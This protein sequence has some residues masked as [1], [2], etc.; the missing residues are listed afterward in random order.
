MSQ[1]SPTLVTI[2]VAVGTQLDTTGMS[3]GFMRQVEPSIKVILSPLSKILSSFDSTVLLLSFSAVILDESCD[4]CFLKTSD[5][6]PKFLPIIFIDYII[7]YLCDEFNKKEAG[8]VYFAKK[9]LVFKHTFTSRSITGTSINT[10]TTAASE[11]PEDKPKSIVE[12][13]IATSK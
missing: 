11:A 2:T 3:S 8:N 12:V 5:N 1:S 10:P 7:A 13:A 6:N 9:C 4:S